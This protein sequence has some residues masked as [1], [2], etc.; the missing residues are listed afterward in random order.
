MTELSALS[1]VVAPFRNAL[2]IFYFIFFSCSGTT[3]RQA[4]KTISRKTSPR[5]RLSP[6]CGLA[7]RPTD[8]APRETRLELHIW[9]AQAKCFPNTQRSRWPRL[10][11]RGPLTHYTRDYTH[12]R[13][14]WV[15]AGGGAV[16][17]PRMRQR[18]AREFEAVLT[19]ISCYPSYYRICLFVQRI[20]GFSPQ[21]QTFAK[22]PSNFLS[23]SLMFQPFF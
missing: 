16:L 13:P 6:A 17:S 18:S 8:R 12:L 7:G 10:W 5:E 23:F 1:S 14:R 19:S 11:P 15:R 22:E 20:Y 4:R 2:R 9:S 3:R 21:K